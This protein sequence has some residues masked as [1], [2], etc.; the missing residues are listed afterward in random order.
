MS[1][2]D[3]TSDRS[4]EPE[5]VSETLI[6]DVQAHLDLL[7]CNNE[8]VDAN[9]F[10][11]VPVFTN[12]VRERILKSPQSQSLPQLSQYS[13][14][15]GNVSD[16]VSFPSAAIGADRRVFYNIAAPTSIFICGSQGSGKSHTLSTLLESCLIP[17]QANQ[18]PRPLTGLVFH[19]DAFT[20]DTGGNA[21]EAAYISS[22][23]TVK[24][25]VLC[26]PTNIG[27][28]KVGPDFDPLSYSE[29]DYVSESTKDFRTF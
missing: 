19:Y 27:H 25:K 20:S 28:I 4:F 14:L 21:C 3:S 12:N 11:A 1:S 29:I 13:L 15:G 8:L 26:A 22:N 7:S 2:L 18:L 6:D 17:C 24:V 10:D 16:D 23:D 5:P 9:A